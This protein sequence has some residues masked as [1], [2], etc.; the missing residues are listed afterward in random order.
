[1]FE[2]FE[3][4]IALYGAAALAGLALVSHT[5]GQGK[6]ANDQR[7]AQARPNHE[8]TR[9]DG[10][11]DAGRFQRETRGSRKRETRTERQG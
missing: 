8:Q 2:L 7:Q 9:P 5:G 10:A 3:W 4:Q 1:M 6:R 11:E